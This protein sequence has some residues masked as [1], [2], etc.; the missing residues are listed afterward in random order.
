MMLVII[1]NI[2]RFS[3]ISHYKPTIFMVDL[4]MKKPGLMAETDHPP[5]AP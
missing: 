3:I 4:S 1:H 2:D 5:L